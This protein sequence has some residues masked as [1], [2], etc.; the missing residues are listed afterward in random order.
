MDASF[1]RLNFHHEKVKKGQVEY[2]TSLK[3]KKNGEPWGV[4]KELRTK[5][6]QN[7]FSTLID[8]GAMLGGL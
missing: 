4:Q 6:P 2:V 1:V 3:L 8:T 5:N 7:F